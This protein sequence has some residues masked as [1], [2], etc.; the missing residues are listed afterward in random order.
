MNQLKWILILLTIILSPFLVYYLFSDKR[1]LTSQLLL[2]QETT[3]TSIST[4]TEYLR[5]DNYEEAGTFETPTPIV[6]TATLD[7]LLGLPWGATF[8]RIETDVKYP[9]FVG[10]VSD[11]GPEINIKFLQKGLW[12]K[13]TGNWKG[14]NEGYVSTDKR[15]CVPIVDIEKIEI[16]N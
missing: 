7:H 11:K 13:I 8:D 9:R 15:K 14:I 16:L 5:C 6:W 1:H 10:W 3:P 12:L 4:I 2:N